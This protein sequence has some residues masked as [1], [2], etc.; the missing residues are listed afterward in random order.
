MQLSATWPLT[1]GGAREQIDSI[2]LCKGA[3]TAVRSKNPV[4]AGWEKNY[5]VVPR[6]AI[7]TFTNAGGDGDI[8]CRKLVNFLTNCEVLSKRKAFDLCL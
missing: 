6:V 7:L 3:R 4:T 1:A 8:T 5:I 2:K